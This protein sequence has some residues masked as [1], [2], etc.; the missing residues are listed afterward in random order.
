MLLCSIL[1]AANL[2]TLGWASEI[3]SIFFK[4]DAWVSCRLS[5]SCL[6]CWSRAHG[7]L[8][9]ESYGNFGYLLHICR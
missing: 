2:L 5:E 4:N 6:P 1:V 8:G 7:P 9:I 3:V